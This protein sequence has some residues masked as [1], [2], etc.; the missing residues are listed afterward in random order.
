[1]IEA[2]DIKK[3]FGPQ[4]VLNGVNLSVANGESIVIIG[5]SGG[6]KSV[7]L[8]I[9][10]GLFA[11]DSGAVLVDGENIV[12]MTER[13]L[14]KVRRKFGMLFQSAALFDSM[15]VAENIAFPLLRE[16]RWPREEL[17]QKI[18]EA[19][20]MV[21]LRGIEEK[22]PS[23]LSGGMRKRVG[24]ARAIVYRPQILLY[25][26]PTTGLDPVVA[27]SIDHLIINIHQRLKVTSITVTHDLR[28]AARVG[29]RILML[30]EGQIYFG[31]TPDEVFSST[32]PVVSRFV[33]GISDPKEHPLKL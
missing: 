20:E 2:R 25:D 27:D 5:A 16:R 1:M 17:R 12:G 21:E 3:F 18:A 6:G 30:H 32:D 29:Q 8:K 4:P 24:L 13:Q 7:L 22:K 28:S 14:L 19:R 15:T 31:G 10:I 11:P 23:A 33:K 9:L 26:E